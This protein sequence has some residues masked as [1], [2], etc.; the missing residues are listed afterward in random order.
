[1]LISVTG[2]KSGRTYTTPVNYVREGDELTVLSRRGRAWWRNL[3]DPAPVLVQLRGKRQAGVGQVLPLEGPGLV[4]AVNG[5][6]AKMGM[7]PDPA[8]IES[9]AAECVAVRVELEGKR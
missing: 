6:Y 5:F 4:E 9:S 2:R 8:K 7:H 3:A 1:M